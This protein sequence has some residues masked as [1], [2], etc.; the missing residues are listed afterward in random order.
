MTAKGAFATTN[1]Q[2]NN[3][4]N[5]NTKGYKMIKTFTRAGISTNKG[6]SLFRFTTS[7][8][9]EKILVDAGHTDIQFFEL[10]TPLSKPDAIAY[11]E[12]KGLKEDRIAKAAKPATAPKAPKAPKAKAADTSDV[13]V[14]ASGDSAAFTKALHLARANFP[15]H[16]ETQLREYVEFQNKLTLGPVAQAAVDDAEEELAAVEEEFVPDF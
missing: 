5:T 16:T 4:T 2:A 7:A 10:D 13:Q 8:T 14:D 9:R 12:A 11:L 6:E 15:S 3:N 1:V